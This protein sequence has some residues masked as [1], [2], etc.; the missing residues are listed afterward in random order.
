MYSTPPPSGLRLE[1]CN[2]GWPQEGKRKSKGTYAASL[3]SESPPQKRSM[4]SRDLTVFRHTHAFIRNRNEPY[5]PL[6]NEVGSRR[7]GML[8]RPWCEVA[9]AE[10]QTYNLPIA[11]PTLHHTVTSA[12]S[13][14]DELRCRERSLTISLA[15]WIQHTSVTDRRT[16]GQTPADSKYR[17][18]A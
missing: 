6:V 12:T 1:L 3:R 15:V 4:F 7:D 11:N 17:V 5:V 8:S 13:S 16:D 18:Y 10:I 2:T 14:N 9:P